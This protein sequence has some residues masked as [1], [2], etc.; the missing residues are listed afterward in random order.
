M[1]Q[2]GIDTGGTFTD[3]IYTA[4]DTWG[5]YKTLSTPSDP[6]R[7]ILSALKQLALQNPLQIVHGSTVATNALLESTGSKT[8]LITNSGFEDSIEIGRQNRRHLYDL[9]YKKTPCLVPENARFGIPGRIDSNG[10]ILEPFDTEKLA[11]IIT[12]IRQ[13]GVE[14]VAVCF[15]FSF[16]NPI[17]EKQAGEM[18]ESLSIP[19]SLSHEIL[20][21]FRE[22]ERTSTTVIN[23]YVAPVMQS[24]I[25]RLKDHLGADDGISIKQS[26]GGCITA[27]TAMQEPV[28]TILS[29]PA[30]GVV[31]A[32]AIGRAAG[33][34]RLITFDMGGTSTDVSLVDGGP[35]LSL[36]STIAGHPVKLPM[37]DIHTVGAGGGSLA[38]VDSGGALKVG[39]QS[40]GADPGP[41][42]YG[43]GTGITVT[44]ANLYLGRLLPGRF[45]GGAM[46]LQPERLDIFFQPFSQKLGLAPRE[47]AQGII[48]IADTAMEKAIRVISVERGYD[49]ADFT[50]F[51]FGGAGGMHAVFLARLLGI[52]RVLVPR[53]PG[54]L[55]ATGMLLA[56]SIKDYSRTIMRE[57]TG[58]PSAT[59]EPYFKDLEDHARRD[60]AAE[61]IQPGQITFERLLDMRYK[62]QSYE[63]L[64]PFGNEY[65]ESFHALHEKTYGYSTAGAAVEI[66][67]TRL[68]ARA[69]PE[70][71]AL[72]KI[73]S[74]SAAPPDAAHSGLQDVYFEG[75]LHSTRVANRDLLLCGNKIQGPAI[76]TEYSSTIVIPPFASGTVDEFG[77][78]I[79]SIHS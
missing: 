2:I 62:G 3:I 14:S 7:A 26:N 66:V 41:I 33:Y 52:P 78:I 56:D 50:L 5:V 76:I 30:G 25:S 13:S 18:L 29:G 10:N 63:L 70:K 61:S 58:A 45:L 8:A 17:H 75:S 6:S 19:V 59:L 38:W 79:I 9:T 35:T 49:P 34:S 72:R 44:D 28:R 15:L 67:N 68:R 42:C 48:D 57:E 4:D 55:S 71:P 1:I 54:I 31:G 24:Y 21:E 37:I 47:L 77:N 23:A 51:S 74:G 43:S 12:D 39:P 11:S 32:H 46:H 36:Q 27:E 22:F 69:V 64:V 73:Q 16:A 40:A 60:F 65:I 53:D 20:S